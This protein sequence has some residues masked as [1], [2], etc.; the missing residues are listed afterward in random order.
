MVSGAATN[1]RVHENITTDIRD[2][3]D[4][5]HERSEGRAREELKV[6]FQ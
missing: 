6:R 4:V 2:L 1:L 5:N 3:R